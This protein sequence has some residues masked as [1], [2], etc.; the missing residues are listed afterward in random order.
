[1]AGTFD[2]RMQQLG[3]SVGEGDLTGRVS[4]DSYYAF[5]VHE[6]LE[7]RHPV[8]QAKFLETAQIIMANV[9]F[10]GLAGNVLNGQFRRSAIRETE[11]FSDQ[12]EALTPVEF[13]DL[14]NNAR[15]QVFDNGG[16][17]Y[18]RAPRIPGPSYEQKLAQRRGRRRRRGL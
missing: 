3:E 17:I 10:A 1:M 16:Q 14:H 5:W 7:L 9:W 6:R 12:A 15:A 2:A 18:H 8:G 13:G 11:R 4:Y